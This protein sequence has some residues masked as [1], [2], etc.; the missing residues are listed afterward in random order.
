MRVLNQHEKELC[1]YCISSLPKTNF[2]LIEGNP[3][4]KMFWGR[5]NIEKATAFYY[6]TKHGKIQNLLHHIKYKDMKEVAYTVGRL[7][8]QDLKQDGIFRDVDYIIPVPLHPKKLK[9]RGYNQSEYFGSGLADAL[10]V[11]ILVNNL[12]RT[13]HSA[14][15]TN[16]S[17]FQ[18]WT[19]VSDIFSLT[20]PELLKNK[21]ILVVDDVITTGATIEASYVAMENLEVRFS[22]ATIAFA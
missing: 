10:H 9:I 2:H 14:T 1:L 20:E 17:R 5:I 7:F 11:P 21:H 13:V 8:G 15:Q 18:R 6:F 3:V 16:K 19:N 4:E 22:V 12:V